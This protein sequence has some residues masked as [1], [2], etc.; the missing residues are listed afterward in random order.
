MRITKVYTLLT[1]VALILTMSG[2]KGQSPTEPFLILDDGPFTGNGPHIERPLED[3][4]N[5][6]GSGRVGRGCP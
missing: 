1:A 3:E 4:C 5:E 2:C 6:V